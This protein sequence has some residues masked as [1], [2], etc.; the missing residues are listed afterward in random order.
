ME[1]VVRDLCVG[2]R[3]TGRGECGSWSEGELSDLSCGLHRPA[4]Y[5]VLFFWRHLETC[6]LP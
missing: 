6:Y 1:V 2:M 4:E 3:G 5:A